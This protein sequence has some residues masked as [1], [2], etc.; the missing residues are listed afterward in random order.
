MKKE[1]KNTFLGGTCNDSTWREDLIEK[2]K[3]PFFNPVVDDWDEE[4]QKQEI[5]ERETAKYVLYVITPLMT[6]TYSIAEVVDD[7]NKRPETTLFCVLEKDGKKS[8]EDFQINSLN[9]VKNMVKKNGAMI[10]NDLNEIANFLNEKKELNEQK[11][12]MQKLAGLEK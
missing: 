2:L 8:F 5:E 3:V 10:F 1:N 9:Q 4:A 11:N 7:S 6:G 12:L